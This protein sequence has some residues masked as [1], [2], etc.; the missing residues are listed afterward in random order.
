MGCFPISYNPVMPRE[1]QGAAPYWDTASAR[2]LETRVDLTPASGGAAGSTW[3][4]I[5]P[6]T[7]VYMYTDFDHLLV[8]GRHAVSGGHLWPI[9]GHWYT[10][11]YHVVDGHIHTQTEKYCPRWS[12]NVLTKPFT[13]SLGAFYIHTFYTSE[14]PLAVK[15]SIYLRKA[16]NSF[17]PVLL[18]M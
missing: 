10:T 3:H 16:T 1:E 7:L 11:L 14:N 9:L 12:A 15:S 8:T 5:L 13:S 17:V 4:A 2:Y 6:S 18:Y